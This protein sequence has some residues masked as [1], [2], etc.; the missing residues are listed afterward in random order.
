MSIVYVTFTLTASLLSVII[1]GCASN[2]RMKDFAYIES[3]GILESSQWSWSFIPIVTARSIM[4]AHSSLPEDEAWRNSTSA[5]NQ[6]LTT[7]GPSEL[8]MHC[9]AGSSLPTPLH[10]SQQCCFRHWCFKSLFHLCNLQFMSQVRK[11]KTFISILESP[12]SR[13]FFSFFFSYFILTS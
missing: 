3:L 4:K 11:R 2:D 1:Q 5:L 7:S 8:S 9:I 10:P 6:V 13:I 12:L